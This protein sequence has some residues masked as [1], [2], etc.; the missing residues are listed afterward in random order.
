M[1]EVER[2]RK[3]IE[4]SCHGYKIVSVDAQEDSIIFTGGTDHNEFAKEIT[5]RT[6][7][8]CERKGKTWGAG[9]MSTGFAAD[10]D[11]I[12]SG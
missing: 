3:L 5:G 1:T 12:G 9:P 6:I 4:D 2:A 7:T 11:G 8:G 10:E